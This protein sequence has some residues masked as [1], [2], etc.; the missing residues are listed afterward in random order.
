VL[1]KDD[2]DGVLAEVF[3]EGVYEETLH[4]HHLVRDLPKEAF[5]VV[6]GNL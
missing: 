3:A 1:T 2:I 5:L 6:T 4:I